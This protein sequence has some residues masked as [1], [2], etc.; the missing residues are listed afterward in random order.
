MYHEH[1]NETLLV[2]DLV[3]TSLELDNFLRRCV[4]LAAESGRDDFRLYYCFLEPFE[5]IEGSFPVDIY[6]VKE[7]LADFVDV[8]EDERVFDCGRQVGLA[9]VSTRIYLEV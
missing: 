6:D 9:F 2:Q 4:D 7:R 5:Y 3:S 1:T 8:C